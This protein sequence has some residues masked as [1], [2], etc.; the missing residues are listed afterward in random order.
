MI[1]ITSSQNSR[2][3]LLKK[4]LTARGINREQAALFS[5]RKIVPE[6]LKHHP[7]RI[8]MCLVP[9]G[10]DR[11]EPAHPPHTELISLKKHL[12]NELDVSGTG[13]P[14]LAVSVPGFPQWKAESHTGLRLCAALQDPA[15]LG[16]AV[17]L[18]AAFSVAGMVLLEE[19]AHPFLPKSLRAAGPA[20][21][22]T[23]F[24]RGPSIHEMPQLEPPVIALSPAGEPI[25]SFRFPRDC[26][27]ISGV[28]GP[29]LPPGTPRS[30]DLR[31]TTSAHVSSLNTVTAIAI[32]LYAYRLQHP[33]YQSEQKRAAETEEPCR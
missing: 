15:N 21:L 17:R 28:E 12:F 25:E 2:Y 11:P 5:G 33:L 18:C 30:A 8:L 14:L 29:G 13:G 27:L 22:T 20:A 19:A 16:A 24:L 1:E 7:D 3:K 23:T 4:L 10:R 32:A 6:L 26:I 31:I 9:F